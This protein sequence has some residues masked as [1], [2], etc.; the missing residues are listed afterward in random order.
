MN[1]DKQADNI[2]KFNCDNIDKYIRYYEL[3]LALA[4]EKFNRVLVICNVIVV[5]PLGLQQQK[6]C[7][8][9]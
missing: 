2:D 9:S 5:C 4:R 7:F 1:K 8:N 6:K 3:K